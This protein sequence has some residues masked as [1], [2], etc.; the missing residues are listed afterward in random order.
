MKKLIEFLKKN[1][2]VLALGIII[3]FIQI[4]TIAS[5][6]NLQK[7]SI[8][9]DE[10]ITLN[11]PTVASTPTATKEQTPT[12]SP[13]PS[14]TQLSDN[15]PTPMNYGNCWP[16]K[17]I[18]CPY[19]MELADAITAVIYNEG[20]LLNLEAG[21]NILQVLHN[22]VI[23]AWT[24]SIRGRRC[25]VVELRGINPNKIP[26]EGIEED[27][28]KRL[29]LYTM[30]RPYT[31]NPS[32]GGYEFPAFN[33]WDMPLK[34][35]VLER[36]PRDM[37][38]YNA[39]HDMVVRYLVDGIGTYDPE[40]YI[41]DPYD[42]NHKLSASP[43]V[44]ENNCQYFELMTGDIWTLRYPRNIKIYLVIPA[45]MGSGDVYN[46]VFESRIWN[47]DSLDY[48]EITPQP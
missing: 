26:F 1:F 37:K 38:L 33:A 44:I 8:A 31:S 35:S 23:G 13:T 40:I 28:F 18:R 3:L 20:G 32:T 45:D 7:Y 10:T 11:T 9:T 2:L 6:R 47:Q 46:L 5:Y 43:A 30:A 19:N 41:V 39:I 48:Y 22:R 14:P 29:I 12:P 27:Q 42:T 25:N 36:N 24:C 34:W 4:S 15:I 21:P 17:K 16:T